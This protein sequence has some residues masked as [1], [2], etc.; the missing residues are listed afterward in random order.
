MSPNIKLILDNPQNWIA[1]LTCAFTVIVGSFTVSSLIIGFL[2]SRK[3]FELK[4]AVYKVKAGLEKDKEQV[5]SLREENKKHVA[6]LFSLLK[7]S[8]LE[9]DRENVSACIQLLQE[10]RE[11]ELN[12]TLIEHTSSAIF[13]L[14][15]SNAPKDKE[16]LVKIATLSEPSDD[17]AIQQPDG[18]L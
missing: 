11:S 9:G 15:E 8:S 6:N 4:E 1:L 16:R 18:T 3:Y 17:D 14:S 2:T 10:N 5:K 13:N 7:D 12:D